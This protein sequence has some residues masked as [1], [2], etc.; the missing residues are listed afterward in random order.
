M[1][2]TTTFNT[3]SKQSNPPSIPVTINSEVKYEI[4]WIINFK[5]DCKQVYKLLYKVIWLD[6]EDMEDKSEWLSTTELIYT[7]ELISNFHTT[8]SSKPSLLSLS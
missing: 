5:I 2:K 4:S 3:L 6:Y 1:L 7:L 8:Y